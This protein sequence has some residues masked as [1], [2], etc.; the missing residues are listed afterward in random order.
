[1]KIQ[2]DSAET[3][4]NLEESL[5]NSGG[6]NHKPTEGDLEVGVSNLVK[7]LWFF[8]RADHR[9]VIVIQECTILVFCTDIDIIGHLGR[10]RVSKRSRITKPSQRHRLLWD[11]G[12]PNWGSFVHSLNGDCIIASKD[13]TRRFED[14]APIQIS[15]V[16][17]WKLLQVIV[18]IFKGRG[19]WPS[20]S[21][22]FMTK[23]PDVPVI[24]ALPY[25]PVS[26]ALRRAECH[27][28]AAG[29]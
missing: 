20:I 2:Q 7:D 5:S 10:C 25:A 8:C 14:S 19:E 9:Y 1:M 18:A 11:S 4:P 29:A 3:V 16:S 12:L 22:L 24:A 23:P 17:R 13:G 26:L 28:Q 27:T 15:L 21:Y 6:A